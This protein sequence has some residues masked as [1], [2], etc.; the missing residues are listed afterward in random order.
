MSRQC[1]KGGTRNE[2]WI[3]ADGSTETQDLS[4]V[5]DNNDVLLRLKDMSAPE[6]SN[7][8]TQSNICLKI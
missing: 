4:K 8:A 3:H 5:N 1:A 2:T 6:V 7:N